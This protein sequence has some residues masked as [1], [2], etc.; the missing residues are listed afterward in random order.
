M[1]F[2]EIQTEGANLVKGYAPGELHINEDRYTEPLVVMPE[3]LWQDW[4]P[5]RSGELEAHHL[6]PLLQSSVEV[7]LIG[8]GDRLEFPDPVVTAPLIN[9]GIGVET[10]DTP[11]ACRTYNI[12]MSEARVVAAILFL[13]EEQG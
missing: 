6:E 13:T 3:G 4:L 7:L 8:T 10:M 1:D 9:G 12:L 11:A 5:A 2:R